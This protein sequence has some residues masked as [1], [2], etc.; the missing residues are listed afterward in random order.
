MSVAST[1]G[2]VASTNMLHGFVAV[3]V[4]TYKEMKVE[5]E[6]VRWLNVCCCGV[7]SV[8]SAVAECLL[9]VLFLNVC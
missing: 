7:M 9:P 8:E 3:P 5:G 4:T 1:D 6:P 2:F